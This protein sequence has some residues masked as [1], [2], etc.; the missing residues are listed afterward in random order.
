MNKPSNALAAGPKRRVNPIPFEGDNG[1]YTQSW[2]PVCLSD[3][4]EQGKVIGREFLGGKIALYRDSK[5]N[6]IAM[7]AY[8]PH[9]GADL[10]VGDVVDD[11][12]RCAFHHWQYDT[13]G[14]CVKLGDGIDDNP[15]ANACI[16]KFP[17][18]ERFGLVFV[19]NGTEPLFEWPELFPYPDDDLTIWTR[20]GTILDCDGWVFSANTPDMQH[21]K[22][23]HRVKFLHDDPHEDVEWNDWGFAYNF[24]GITEHGKGVKLEWK[25]GILGSNNFFQMGTHDGRWYGVLACYSCPRPG[26]SEVFL[27]ILTPKGDGSP[28][29]TAQIEAFMEEMMLFEQQIV[30]EDM[31]ILCSINYKPG[32]LLKSDKSLG[33]F[34]EYIRKYPRA[35]P[36]ADFIS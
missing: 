17:V 21:L 13:D 14:K 24:E 12:L 32:T 19:F 25:I 30:T 15:P 31:P 10:T 7:S 35:H 5:N 36:S 3:E 9:L 8:C 4:L 1:L 22:V 29:N 20:R 34:L 16:F 23:V 2:F 6:P 26:K 33:R 28:E 11:N 18:M 27:S